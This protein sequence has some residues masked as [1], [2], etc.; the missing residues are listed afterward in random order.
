MQRSRA[1]WAS[2]LTLAV[3]LV[4]LVLFIHAGASARMRALPTA[5]TIAQQLPTATG[6]ATQTVRPSPAALPPTNTPRPPAP[7]RTAV[8]TA[9]PS[10]S[11]TATSRATATSPPTMASSPTPYATLVEP[12]LEQ[13]LPTAVPPFTRPANVTNIALL[14][15]DA[16]GRN[17]GRTD[18]II[19]VSINHELRTA[20]MLSL[21]RDIWVAVPG[22][23]MARINQALPH[24]N[25]TDYPGSGGGMLKDT[26][27][28]NFGIPVDYYLRI[29]FDGFKR[30][31]DALGGV[32]VAVTCRVRDWRLIEPELDP[33]VEENWEMFTLDTG[34][35]HMDGDLALWYVRSRRSSSDFD[36]GRRQ[37]QVLRAMFNRGLDRNFIARLPELWE[38]YQYDIETDMTLPLLL[39][40]AAL[41]PAVRDNGIQ[42]LY[43]PPAA[44]R[45]W[46]TSGGGAVQ[47][48]Q[49]EAAQPVLA[50]LMQP[51]LL[52]HAS[53]P[54][55]TVEV[56]SPF[57]FTY[58]LA[59]ETLAWYGFAP[60]RGPVGGEM[61]SRTEVTYFGANR[62]GSFDWLLGWLVDVRPENIVLEPTPGASEYDYRVVLGYNY[63]SCRPE[64]E[65]PS[66]P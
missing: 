39:Q 31:V 52:N 65:I 18:S 7:T 11:A 59:A 27:R 21:P 35:H 44:L 37:Q 15:N 66:P 38:A 25:V 63:D 60:V 56:V 3:G 19:I 30:V 41:A 42:H 34:I 12:P 1:P 5:T 10:P 8:P 26:I 53:R 32:T 50:R 62:K 28:Y 20:T 4:S 43:L 57:E 46:T 49:W 2:I 9:T 48:L 40:L 29:G 23:R 61:P 22:W 54:P 55:I 33:D 45:S 6:T 14:G 51:P 24:G 58:Q 13:L 17:G 47:R 36:R 16:P 64:R